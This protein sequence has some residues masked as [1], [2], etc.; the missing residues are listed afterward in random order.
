[1]CFRT[2]LAKRPSEQ[3]VEE[4]LVLLV[5]QGC[6]VLKYKCVRK[7]T[8]DSLDNLSYWVAL[9]MSCYIQMRPTWH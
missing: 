7:P 5:G 9:M 2:S 8:L 4:M 1:M 3:F 6:N